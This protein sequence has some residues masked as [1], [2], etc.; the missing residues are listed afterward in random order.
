MNVVASVAEL[1]APGGIVA[2]G[3][4]DGVHLGH[5][6]LLERMTAWGAAE[7]RPTAIVTFFPPAKVL[8]QGVKYLAS[9]EEKLALLEPF[10]PTGIALLHFDRGYAQTDKATFLAELASLEP[11]A[12]IVGEDF[13]FGRGRAGGL[14]DLQHVAERLE[15]F[16]LEHDEGSAISSSRIREA[17]Q[18]GDVT[19]ANRL[20]G[21]P[22]LAI[23]EV[24]HGDQRGRTIGFPTANLD[25]DDAKALPI[26][27]FAVTVHAAAGRFSGMANVGPRPSF[28]DGSPRL[29]VHL[30]DFDGDLYGSRLQVH[31]HARIRGQRRFDGLDALKTR[32]ERDRVAARSILASSRS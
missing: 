21:G 20:L 11:H 7:R 29:E 18:E 25:L 5:R 3:N 19:T 9:R 8:F 15:V 30:F 1:V 24:V 4:F 6:R 13:R 26:G 22:Y 28:P 23:G 2:I 17:L 12:V 31:F 27:V 14:D 32:L 10:E 16:G